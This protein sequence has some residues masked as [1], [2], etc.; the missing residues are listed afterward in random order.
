MALQSSGQISF[1]NIINEFGDSGGGL[2]GYRLNQTIGSLSGLRLDKN[3][4]VFEFEDDGIGIDEK[5]YE[6]AFRPFSRLD[7]SRN[8]NN[9][10]GVGLG[11]SIAN[12]VVRMHGG[13][14]TLYKS[15]DLGGLGVRIRIPI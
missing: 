1:A 14:I 13:Q 4:L 12:D 7:E 10:S 2:G 11:L 3:S 15:L 6:K 5:N 9:H 8:Q